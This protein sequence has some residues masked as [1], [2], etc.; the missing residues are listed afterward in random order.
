MVYRTIA[1]PDASERAELRELAEMARQTRIRRG[2]IA[3]AVSGAV[4]A[5]VAGIL[6]VLTHGPPPAELECHH[7]RVVY[8]N[9]RSTPGPSWTACEW[10]R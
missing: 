3:A 6:G 9:Q 10:R 5:G 7:V 8:E 4:L 2:R 1:D